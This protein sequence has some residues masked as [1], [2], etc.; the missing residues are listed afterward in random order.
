MNPIAAE[1]D[2]MG[3]ADRLVVELPRDS[4]SHEGRPSNG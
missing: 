3:P 4:W 1:I 2:G